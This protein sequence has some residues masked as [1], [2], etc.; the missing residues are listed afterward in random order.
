MKGEKYKQHLQ[1]RVT[2]HFG[3]MLKQGDILQQRVATVE[4][5]DLDDEEQ[6]RQESESLELFVELAIEGRCGLLLREFV[7]LV[8]ELFLSR[9]VVLHMDI[10]ATTG[11]SQFLT[12]LLVE[13]RHDGIACII[14]HIVAC[15]RDG[16]RCSL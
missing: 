5:T 11:L 4:D 3:F 9:R 8:V 7:E 2:T 16:D 12:H 6:E 10:G 14:L 13:S 1:H 15:A